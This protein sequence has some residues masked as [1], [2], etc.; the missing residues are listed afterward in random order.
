MSA[1]ENQVLSFPYLQQVDQWLECSLLARHK[2]SS[3]IARPSN[4]IVSHCEVVCIG[5]LVEEPLQINQVYENIYLMHQVHYYVPCVLAAHGLVAG[6]PQHLG[7]VS[8]P[9]LVQQTLPDTQDM[10]G[11]PC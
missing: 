6:I 5:L 8:Q 7:H 10:T 4:G 3:G 9:S 2:E 1:I 11:G